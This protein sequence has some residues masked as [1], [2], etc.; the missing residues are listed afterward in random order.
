MIYLFVAFSTIAQVLQQRAIEKPTDS[1]EVASVK[2][3]KSKVWTASSDGNDR[4]FAWAGATLMSTISYAWKVLPYQV[5]G[6]AWLDSERYDIEAIKPP[7]ATEEQVRIML[8]NLL[9]ERFNLRVHRENKEMLVY[10]LHVGKHGPKFKHSPPTAVSQIRAPRNGVE[11]AASSM[12]GLS[13]LLMR[14]TDRIVVDETG[15]EGLYDF[16]LT[17]NT[18]DAPRDTISLG[19]ELF[20]A[21]DEQLGLILEAKKKAIEVLA[22]DNADKI[23]IDN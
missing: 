20:S 4:R 21:L 5:R 6:P 9:A 13:Y 23:P 22:V 14:W 15:L 2:P 10:A 11:G 7:A 8:Q 17:L 12:A 18:G 19:S 16:K 3:N 1:F